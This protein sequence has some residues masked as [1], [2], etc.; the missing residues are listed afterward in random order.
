MT[1]LK[2]I[3]KDSTNQLKKA[4]IDNADLDA[5]IL[6]GHI[7]NY[8]RA[9]LITKSENEISQKNTDEINALIKRRLSREPV[10][11][12]LGKREFW[13]LPFKLNKYTLEPRPDSEILVETAIKLLKNNDRK[14]I[15]DIGTGTGCLLLS[16]LSEIKDATGIGI[17][18]SKNAIKQAK[19]NAE[20]LNL[21][22]RSSFK[23]SNWLENINETFDLIISNPPYISKEEITTL[24][25]EVKD[26]DPITALDG[27]ENGLEP[28]QYLIPIL[29]NYL[30]KNGIVIFEVGANQSKEVKDLMKENN[31]TNIKIKN[32]LGNIERCVCGVL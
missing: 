6:I 27:G 30:N 3:L 17:D 12:I 22:K 24:Q 7:L 14:H 18:I 2:T 25:P 29:P 8:D 11:R 15:L 13:G 21:E 1:K 28:Y 26:F 31:F 20:N 32:D 5:K 10:A 4:G 23:I 9:Q 19:E 16:I